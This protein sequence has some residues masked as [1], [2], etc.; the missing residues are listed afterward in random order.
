MT[1][2]Y[3][4][5]SNINLLQMEKVYPDTLYTLTISKNQLR[6]LSLKKRYKQYMRLIRKHILPYLSEAHIYPELSKV[7]RLHL[8]GT[9]RFLSDDTIFDFYDNIYTQFFSDHIEIDTISDPDKWCT[10]I[11]KQSRFKECYSQRLIPYRLKYER[12]EN[13]I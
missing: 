7:G 12:K 5:S 1:H 11:T 6:S 10:Y 4:K 8:H 9:I 13:S 3:T 2:A